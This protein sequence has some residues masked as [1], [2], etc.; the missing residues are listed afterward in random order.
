M[1]KISEK[2]PVFEHVMT[3]ASETFL[4]R[5]DDYPWERN[6]WNIHPE[7]EIH[8][9]RN[10]SG[11]ALIGDFIGQFEPGNLTIVGGGLPHDWV[12]SVASGEIIPGR[13]IVLQFDPQRVRRAADL[14]PEIKDISPFLNLA[15][16][17]IRFFGE[18]QKI[19]RKIME[20]MGQTH[21]IERLSQFLQL[22]HVLS[23]SSEY[24]VLSSEGFSPNL[25]SKTLDHV[26]RVLAYVFEN[27][28]SDIN[29]SDLAGMVGMSENNFSRFFKKNSGNSFTD[30][31]TK[32][33]ISRACKL[34]SDSD[35]PITDICFEVGYSNISNFN[36]LFLNQRGITPSK[37]RQ[38][39]K[40]R[41]H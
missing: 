4:W 34:L 15:L 28:T 41:F 27:F 11:V 6:V 5:C 16:R 37:Y 36:R 3:G 8:L 40:R 14:L 13:D 38:L 22:L 19:G 1:T 2:R 18:T 32:L 30:H 25:D 35:I 9:I 33:R 29:L 39:A 26:Q 10:A 21:G 7:Y 23:T 17:G 31:I 24:E 12:T 20:Q